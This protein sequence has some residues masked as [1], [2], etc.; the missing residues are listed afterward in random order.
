MLWEGIE[1]P[2][3]ELW[4]DVDGSGGAYLVSNYG[5]V[6]SLKRSKPII[7]KEKV[8]K[9]GYKELCFSFGKDKWYP[10]VHR[11]VAQHFVS[12]YKTELVVN[13]KDNTKDNNMYYNLEWCT[14]TENTIKYYAEYHKPRS[15]SS[16]TKND[17]L[18]IKFLN[19]NG[20][21]YAAICENLNIITSKPCNLGDVLKG[22]RLSSIT[23][24]TE[25]DRKL[26]TIGN[27]LDKHKVQDILYGR[28]ISKLPLKVLSEKYG[29]TDSV[30]SRVCNG[31]RWSQEY[32]DFVSKHN[33][34]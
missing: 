5:R 22:R 31:T 30:V 1:F 26:N 25:S 20:I 4:K 33:I 12:G 3:K 34:E 28:L 16:L 17:W 19:H 2:I 6:R 29:V 11:L 14:P 23:G 21:K 24:F 27:K 32:K 9:D 8:D 13:H 7:L 10:R 18:Y 15:L